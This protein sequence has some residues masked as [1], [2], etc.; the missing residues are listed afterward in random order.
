VTGEVGDVLA[1]AKSMGKVPVLM[2]PGT[3]TEYWTRSTSLLHADV[4]GTKDQALDE[5]VRVYFIAGA[6]HTPTVGASEGLYVNPAN[7][8]DWRPI[9]R[10]LLPALDLWATTGAPP[11]DSVYPRIDRG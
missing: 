2:Y 7:P 3:S 5:H 10:A 8:L 6:Q 11:P 4:T 9:V 1:V